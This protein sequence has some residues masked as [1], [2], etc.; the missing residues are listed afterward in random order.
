MTGVQTCALP[1]SHPAKVYSFISFTGSGMMILV[2]DR[3]FVKA[4]FP[5]IFTADD[6]SVFFNFS[7]PKKEYSPISFNDVGRLIFSIF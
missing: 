6:I 4:P 5:I 1:I 3:Q 7:H 2:N